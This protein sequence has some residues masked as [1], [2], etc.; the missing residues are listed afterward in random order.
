M[1]NKFQPIGDRVVVKPLS[2]DVSSGGVI[3]PDVSQE[4]INK[5]EVVAVGPGMLLLDGVRGS[6][7]CSVGDTVVYTKI[8]A[9]KFDEDE[10]LYVVKENDLLT[11]IK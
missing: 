5:A 3:M 1:E 2:Q 4:G 9:K 8:S 7:Q 11:I 6:M 10:N